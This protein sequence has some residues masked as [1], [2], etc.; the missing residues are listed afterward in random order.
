MD[1]EDEL[2]EGAEAPEEQSSYISREKPEPEDNKAALIT[3]WVSRVQKAKKVYDKAYRRMDSCMAM[4]DGYQWQEE[5]GETDG[6]YV[7][8]IILRHVHQ[9]TSALYAR[10]PTVVAHKRKRRI[11]EIWDGDRQKILMAHQIVMAAQQFMQDAS[12]LALTQ[13]PAIQ[14]AMQQVMEANALLQDYQAGQ[15][16]EQQI[17]GLSETLEVLSNYF[18]EEQ[19]PRF[20]LQMKQA[21]R[22]ALVSGVAYSKLTFQRQTGEQADP[23]TMASLADA[24]NRLARLQQLAADKMDDELKPEDA[25]AEELE[26]M[27]E[28]LKGATEEVIIREGPVWAFP[29]A[30]NVIVDPSCREL[31]DFVGANWIAEEYLLTVDQVKQIYGQD[32]SA[33][34]AGY[35]KYSMDGKRMERVN[36]SV[37]DV[38][39]NKAQR[40][41]L[42]CVWEIYDK[43]SGLVFTLADGHKDY[44]RDPND[45]L[46]ITEQFFPY[47]TLAF[48]QSESAEELF[49]QSDVWLLRHP[50]REYNRAREALRQH[51]WANRPLYVASSGWADD[52]DQDTLAG[53]MAH[54][55]ITLKGLGPNQSVN[56]LIQPMGKHGIDPNMYETASLF[57]DVQRV[58]GT[59][60]ANIG[61]LAT[62]ATAT[63][64][65]I[66]ESSRMS[67]VGSQSDDLDDMLTAMK[68]AE[69]QLMLRELTSDTVIEIVGKGAVWGELSPEEIV[70]E[71]T[72]EVEAGSS[73]R[74]NQA[75]DVQT[76]QQM[77]PLLIQI[78]GVRPDKLAEVGL[79]IMDSRFRLEDFL[80]D[81]LPSIVSMNS[82]GPQVA[83]GDP[84]TDPAQQGN[85]GQ[86]NAPQPDQGGA[87]AVPGSPGQPPQPVVR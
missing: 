6:P 77:V 74:P 86:N 56:D 3:Q 2:N 70:K 26:L 4:T 71:I 19:F 36:R 40:D 28:G 1:G 62:N 60:E 20:K 11:Y 12:P 46:V 82:Q 80:D 37:F 30:Q 24:R 43:V 54:D 33:S 39:N 45:P 44:L 55:I 57:D 13:D 18:Q 84:A 64:T 47:F 21:V 9:R 52:E 48:N 76:F 63:E 35:T 58:V 73:G 17:D 75:A 50:Q 8:N 81:A 7:A 31:I 34:G 87:Q 14:Q 53:A 10:N 61:G 85:Q 22:R 15:A 49:P 23:S 67:S 79:K 32:V 51:R 29:R 59:Q 65:S 42:V 25:E 69:G 5:Y 41:G 78:P 66:A 72:L 68:R 16:Y 27:I 38:D 83:T